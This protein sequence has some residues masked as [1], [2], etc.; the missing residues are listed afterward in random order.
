VA[1]ACANMKGDE[2]MGQRPAKLDLMLEPLSQFYTFRGAQEVSGFL[3]AHPFLAP[4]LLEAYNKIA[5]HYGPSPQ[6][7]LEVVTDPEATDDRELFVF[8]RTNLPPDEALSK[9]DQLDKEW[10]LDEAD[11]AKGKLCIHVE[12]Q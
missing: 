4:L 6:V 9:L 8:I 7:V 10:W 5:K 1:K 3:H 12:F 11:R 2:L